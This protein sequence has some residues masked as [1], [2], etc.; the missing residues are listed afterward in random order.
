MTPYPHRCLSPALQGH[1]IG[2][3]EVLLSAGSY[4]S[5]MHLISGEF[6][7][8]FPGRAQR[9]WRGQGQPAADNSANGGSQRQPAW[10]C[11]RG[12]DTAAGTV[13]PLRRALEGFTV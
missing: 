10:V 6:W 8:S 12:F 5:P 4:H 13:V 7:L 3:G 9:L 1:N 2:E 11:R